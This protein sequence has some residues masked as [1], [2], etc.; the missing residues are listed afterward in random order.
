MRVLVA[1]DSL[2]ARQLLVAVLEEDPELQVVGQA[3]NGV[4][5]VALTKSLRP[6]L[7]TMDLHMPLLDGFEATKQIMIEAPT[8]IVIVS[9]SEQVGEVKLA[10]HA[11]RVGALTVLE[12]PVSPAAPEF[13]ELCAT[14][15]ST[16]KAL[17]YV[18][19]VRRWR[20]RTTAE[21]ALAP[22][23]E[24]VAGVRLVALAASTGG[25]AVLQ[26][27]LG[28]LPGTFP[29]PIAVVQHIARGFVPGFVAWLNTGCPLQ[30]RLAHDGEALLPGHVYLA[31]EEHHLGVTE[32]LRA[33][34][35]TSPPVGGFRPSATQLFASAAQHL[36]G[37]V[38]A[39]ILTGMGNDGVEGLVALR[40]AG[41]IVLAQD[42]ASSVVYGMP[43]AAVA[44]GAV[45]EVLP[46]SRLAER[47]HDLVHRGGGQR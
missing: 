36:G 47:I 19:V 20:E 35:T 7:V 9:A 38:V 15:R 5:A 11:L 28:E 27:L 23:P 17:A 18:K 40:R 45:H 24:P 34:L 6:D 8:P 25:P 30:V 14:L 13:A 22:R 33:H 39:A 4:E 32:A 44:A 1:E 37:Q 16:V 41:G 2:T 31:P 29:V 26:R 43:G 10:M 42:E 12:K 46:V 3:G 21:V